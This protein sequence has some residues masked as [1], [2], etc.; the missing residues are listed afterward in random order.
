MDV[1]VLQQGGKLLGKGIY[2]CVFD[3]PLKCLKS[4]KK[5]L[6][7]KK[8]KGTQVAK[9]TFEEEAEKEFKVSTLLSTL[10]TAKEYFIL[11]E[12]LCIPSP[13]SEQTEK[14]LPLCK[15]L[16]GI[17]LSKSRQLTMPFGGKSLYS[18][19]YRTDT[20]SFFPIVQKLLEMGSL[21]FIK[22]L[23]HF[24][25]HELNILCDTPSSIKV[26]DF[27]ISWEVSELTSKNIDSLNRVFKPDADHVPPEISLLH[28]LN[29][30]KRM[31]KELL[32]AQ[33]QDKKHALKVVETLFNISRDVQ[34]KKLTNFSNNS[35][36]F[37]EKKWFSYF[38]TYW[39]KIDAW[40]IGVILL[41]MYKDMVFDP[42]FEQGEL[43]ENKHRSAL[44]TIKGLCDTDPSKRLNAV[45]ALQL[46]APNS[47]ILMYPELQSWLAKKYAD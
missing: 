3:K 15:P 31:P 24:D 39:S 5:T 22:Q 20:L 43:Y 16:V 11:V 32:L 44:N 18:I 34:I 19:P 8:V 17:D 40:S 9:L 26:I 37:R 6:S 13:R 38:L 42:T 23:V 36:L 30:S 4:G 28:G 33:I 14:D 21:L 1:A 47:K 7:N 2:G 12:E 45:E 41:N 35:K 10:P 27:G 46:Y 25:L 29:S